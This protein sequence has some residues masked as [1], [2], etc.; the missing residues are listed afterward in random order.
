MSEH[1]FACIG[2]SSG[3]FSNQLGYYNIFTAPKDELTV[4]R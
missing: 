4:T 3:I 1:Q 2:L